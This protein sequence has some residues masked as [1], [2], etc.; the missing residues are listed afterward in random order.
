MNDKLSLLGSGILVALFFIAG[1]LDLL[2][3]IIVKML[4]FVTFLGIVINIVIV[5]SKD[6]HKKN[7]P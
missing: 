3:N 1:L 2:G 7:L 6:D 4:L 5:K